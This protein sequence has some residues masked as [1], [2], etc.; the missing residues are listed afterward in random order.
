MFYPIFDRCSRYTFDG[1]WKDIF[2]GMAN[3]KFPDGIKYDFDTN[4]LIFNDEVFV[5][6]KTESDTFVEVKN[7]LQTKLHV[8]STRDIFNLDDNSES[9]EENSWKKIRSKS[10]KDAILLNFVIETFGEINNSDIRKILSKLCLAIQ[11]KDISSDDIFIEDNKIK[12]IKNF[13]PNHENCTFT[14]TK[15]NTAQNNTQKNEKKTPSKRNAFLSSVDKYIKERFI[16]E[17]NK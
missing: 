11:F 7:I 12:E 2:T 6:P 10:E 15:K 8:Y 9:D 14:L 16:R 3:G 5:L 4:S 13:I 17:N 1:F